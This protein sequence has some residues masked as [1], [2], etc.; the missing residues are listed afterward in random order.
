MVKLQ[1][2]TSLSLSLSIASVKPAA[3]LWRG[4]W[5]KKLRQA[6]F[7]DQQGAE[8]LIST[9]SRE[10]NPVNRLLYELGGRS[11]PGE[12]CNDR[13]IASL[14]AVPLPPPPQPP[15]SLISLLLP[16]LFSSSISFSLVMFHVGFPGGSDSKESA[17]KAGDESWIPGW[18]RPPGKGNGNPLQYSCL[19]N[20]TDRGSWWV[21]SM[22]LQRI[23]H[24]WAP[25]T[26]GPHT[27]HVS[28]RS[29]ICHFCV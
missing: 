2:V 14:W 13:L 6:S 10:L 9:A 25:N 15:V 17:C 11:V 5:N 16:F 3:V 27:Y 23:R 18:G 26:F 22:R 8:T 12:T 21:P 20:S 4:P 7:S 1:I 19:E 24:D 29:V 28:C